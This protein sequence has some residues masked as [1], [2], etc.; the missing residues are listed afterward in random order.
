MHGI[1]AQIAFAGLTSELV[2]EQNRVLAL[3]A[4][5]QGKRRDEEKESE[6]KKAWGEMQKRMAAEKT[7]DAKRKHA[8]CVSHACVRAQITAGL[9]SS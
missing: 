9:L 4:L 6:K 5:N 3:S 2:T 1:P 8:R 7:T